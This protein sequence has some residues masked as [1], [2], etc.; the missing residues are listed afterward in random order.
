MF[1]Q[2]EINLLCQ[3]LIFEESSEIWDHLNACVV[4]KGSFIPLLSACP[5][6]GQVGSGGLEPGRVHQTCRGGCRGT[7]M[8]RRRTFSRRS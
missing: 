5:V 8:Q 4:F 2:G 7:M 1:F 6:Q 3:N